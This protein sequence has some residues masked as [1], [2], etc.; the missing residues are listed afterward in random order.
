[1]INATRHLTIQLDAGSHQIFSGTYIQGT[2]L[3]NEK[4]FWLQQNGSY[5]IWCRNVFYGSVWIIG[6]NANLGQFLGH[7]LVITENNASYPLAI[8]SHLESKGI[9]QFQ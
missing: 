1:M 3:V 8:S 6:H 5:R 4:P 9:I 7:I 2:G